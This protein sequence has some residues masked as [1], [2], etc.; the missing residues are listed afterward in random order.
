MGRPQHSAEA[1]DALQASVEEQLHR[2]GRPRAR[3][4]SIEPLGGGACQELF[5]LTVDEGGLRRDWV[6]RVDAATSLPGSIRRRAEF[7]VVQ[8]AAAAGVPTPR[9]HALLHDLL[10]PGADGW[11]MDRLPGQALGG[12]V[13]GARELA[14]ARALLPDQLAAALVFVHRLDPAA[15][16]GLVSALGEAPDDPEGNALIELRRVLDGLPEARPALELALRWAASR[17]PPPSPVRLVHGDFRVGNFL[18]GP[19][20]LVAVLDWEFARLGAP[21]ED[22]AWLCVRDWRFG[23][24]DKAAGGICSREAFRAAYVAAGGTDPGAAACH[25]WEVLGNLRWAAGSH[26]QALRFFEEEEPDIELLAIGRRAVE[27]E[28]EALRLIRQGVPAG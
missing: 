16:P 17:R 6:L 25:W 12:K 18:V 27:M 4:V 1:L 11:L 15:E 13:V 28:F 24:I 26:A 20:G 21:A 7:A 23:K 14:G 5:A 19:A 10:R 2:Q 8:I 22:I 9:G 3:V